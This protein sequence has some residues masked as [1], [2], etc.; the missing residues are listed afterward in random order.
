VV[1]PEPGKIADAIHRYFDE[2][3]EEKFTV[4]VEEEKKRFGW[5]TMIRTI[6][7]VVNE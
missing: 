7:E 4:N 6:D 2:D 1:E 3:L 5:D